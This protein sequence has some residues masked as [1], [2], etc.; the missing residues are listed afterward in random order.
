[1]H[2]FIVHSNESV[3][4]KSGRLGLDQVVSGISRISI[5]EYIDEIMNAFNKIDPRN[6]STKS[7]AAP[8][9]LF[10]VDKDCE[11]ISQDKAKGLHN[12]VANTIYTTKRDIPD[13]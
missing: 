9:N 2:N 3:C 6:R 4:R 10:K 12:L 7:S 13:I 8:E 11:K 1:M 5:M